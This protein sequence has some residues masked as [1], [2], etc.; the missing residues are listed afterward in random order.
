MIYSLI[1]KAN[2][3]GQLAF[4]KTREIPMNTKSSFRVTLGIMPDYTY[5]GEGIR[6]DGITD[7]KIAQK[8][9]I[10]AGDIILQI[11]THTFSGMQSYM[12]TLNKFSK[13]DAARVR[14]K[15]SAAELVFDIVF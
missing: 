7:G 14:V 8:A 13:G 12:E 2:I 10:Q 9:G 3:K 6:A 1:E 5:S 15:R 11:G 4:T